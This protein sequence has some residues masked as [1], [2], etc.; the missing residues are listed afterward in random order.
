M[1]VTTYR[2]ETTL[3]D[4]IM[5][6]MFPL[7]GPIRR[8]IHWQPGFSK[9][10]GLSASVSFLPLPLPAP[11]LFNFLALSP[12][13][14]WPKHS[15]VPRSLCAPKP[16]GNASYAGYFQINWTVLTSMYHVRYKI[17]YMTVIIMGDVLLSHHLPQ[18]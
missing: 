12:F 17:I 2:Y 13:F 14:V 15:I 1:Q 5:P 4:I 7:A 6:I 3:I 10:R 9:S 11:H 16:Q 8:P 18:T